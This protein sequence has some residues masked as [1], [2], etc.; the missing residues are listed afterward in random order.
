MV[1]PPRLRAGVLTIRLWLEEDG[2]PRPR[3]RIT[4]TQDVESAERVEAVA[5]DLDEIL[6]VV[7]SW[8]ES[9]VSAG[10]LGPGAS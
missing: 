3:A 6:G 10:G 4:F 7:Q 1:G 9:F 8:L 2:A 5:A